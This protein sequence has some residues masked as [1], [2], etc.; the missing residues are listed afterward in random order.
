MAETTGISWTTSTF[1]PWIGC[2]KVGPGCDH[3]YA[4]SEDA[5]HKWGG[6]THWGA[7]V[8]RHH[9]SV[10]L[11]NNPHKW[12]K[13]QE[14][15]L[16]DYALGKGPKPAPWRVFCAS[17]ADVFD[18]EVPNRW[19]SELWDTI[20]ATPYLT[21]QL[22]TKRVG[23]VA[24]M[25]PP[26]WL[27][28]WPENVWIVATV[29]NQEEFDR[30]W[31]KLAAVPAYVRG[32]SVEPMLGSITFPEEVRGKLHWV[33]Y[34]GESKQPTGAARPCNLRWILDGIKQCREFGVAPFLKQLGHFVVNG[35]DYIDLAGVTGKG[36]DP[37][38][39]H[40]DLRVQEFPA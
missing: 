2:T 23:N 21:W 5:R 34:G 10:A 26:S 29:V 4:E 39:W 6:A 13:E 22:V 14:R 27:E 38:E 24:K 3:C 15:R 37:K 9:T 7:G 36:A 25:V 1:N 33:I 40:P 32:L 18:N 28:D 31:P 17:L 35:T 19:R 30:D 11:W 8:P 12:N 16:N 20:R